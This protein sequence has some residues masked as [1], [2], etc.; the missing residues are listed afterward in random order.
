MNYN[1]I[2]GKAYDCLVS[3]TN[4]IGEQT[5]VKAYLCNSS[6]GNYRISTINDSTIV[7]KTTREEPYKPHIAHTR[8]RLLPENFY[9]LV[10]S[11]FKPGDSLGGKV[12]VLSNQPLLVRP[13][14]AEGVG[15]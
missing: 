13:I 8:G 10:L 6:V 5:S 15:M 7:D 2:T 4:T 9:T 14:N 3:F 11:S 12:E 1:A